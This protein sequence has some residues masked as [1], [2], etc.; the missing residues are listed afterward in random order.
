MLI[1]TIKTQD[2]SMDYLRFGEGKKVLVILPG[3]SVQSLLPS[4]GAIATM[5][6]PFTEAY[7]VYLFERRKDVP[8]VYPV[9]EMARDTAVAMGMLGLKDVCLYGISQG[10]M[11]AMEIALQDPGLVRKLALASTTAR[12][13][14]ERF[15]RIGNWIRLAEAGEAEALYLSF[16]A[17]VYP[18][19]VFSEYREAFSLI[20]KTVTAGE[21]ER[22]VIL[23]KAITELDLSGSLWRITCP[24][25][26]AASKDDLL[27]GEPAAREIAEAV[28]GAGLLLYDGF[29][30]A[31]YDTAPDFVG[32]LLE[33]FG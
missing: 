18:P 12:M 13:T 3:L 32:R 29:G 15:R 31:V 8:A 26:A 10:G 2:F 14:E 16:G 24:T 5:Y 33:F 4:A 19:A 27:F 30:H 25:L 7:T 11:I 22:F 9:R 1:Q 28:P 21:L 20:S 17:D 23:A 6:R